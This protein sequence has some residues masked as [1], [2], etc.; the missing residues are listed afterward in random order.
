MS[1]PP[2]LRVLDLAVVPRAPCQRDIDPLCFGSDASYGSI[3]AF[4]ARFGDL[5][6]TRQ[7]A[8]SEAIRQ[9][10]IPVGDDPADSRINPA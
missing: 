6:F 2:S 7:Q 1:W 9:P 10:S 5:S 8:I 4:R 3:A